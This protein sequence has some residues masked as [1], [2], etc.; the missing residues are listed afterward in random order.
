MLRRNFDEIPRAHGAFEWLKQGVFADAWN[1]AEHEP[2]VDLLVRTLRAMGEKCDDVADAVGIDAPY[3]RKPRLGLGRVT[4]LNRRRLIQIEHVT[5]LRSIHP[6]SPI[7]LS[8]TSC[9]SPGA[10]V[11][12]STGACLASQALAFVVLG[13]PVVLLM[14]GLPALSFSGT[15]G[16]LALTLAAGQKSPAGR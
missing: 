11:I 9:G 6:P 14:T 13:K 5:P 1:A 4:K 3:V 12:C 16:S 8:R 2:V 7:N 10:H 15:G